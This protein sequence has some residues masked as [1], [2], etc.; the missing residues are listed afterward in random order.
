MTIKNLGLLEWG[1][2]RDMELHR[3]YFAKFL[4]ETTSI[5][6][7]PQAMTFAPGL[8]LIGAPWT[9]GTDNDQYAVCT[10]TVEC[11]SVLKREANVHWILKYTFTTRPWLICLATNITDPISQPDVVSGSFVNYQER[12][13]KRRDGKAIVSSSL[14]PI[15]VQKDKCLPTVSITQT[16]LYLELPLIAEMVGT[17]NNGPLWGLPKRYVRLRNVPW[18]RLVWG[19][20]AFYYQRTLEFDVDY[21][22]FDLADVR[23]QGHRVIDKSKPGYVAR[24]DIYGNPIETGDL[25]TIDRTNPINFER[26]TDGKGNINKVGLLDL[27]GEYCT[28]PANHEHYISKVEL[29]NESNFLLLGVPVIL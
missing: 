4:L 27:H 14:E 9:Y 22:S 12:V 16:R 7:G 15:W 19:R 13:C 8:P 29:Y 21:R 26:G 3:T 23:D 25:G 5:Y 1:G 18:R 2:G 28:D 10:P 11:E 20:C 24:A 6:D 17:L